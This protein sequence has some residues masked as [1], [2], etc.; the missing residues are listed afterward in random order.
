[1]LSEAFDRKEAIYNAITSNGTRVLAAS[2]KYNTGGLENFDDEPAL[3]QRLA[4]GDTMVQYWTDGSWHRGGD[5]IGLSA[6]AIAFQELYAGKQRWLGQSMGLGSFVG[7]SYDS[8]VQAI[9]MAL[10]HAVDRHRRGEVFQHV[11]V[12]SDSQ[13]VL[14]MLASGIHV[15]GRARPPYLG[16]LPENGGQWALEKIYGRADDLSQLG[17]RV[18][19]RWTR[20]HE[21][22]SSHGNK[23]ADD[24]AK[25]ANDKQIE[26]LGTRNIWALNGIVPQEYSTPNPVR[27]EYLF[28]RSQP[29]LDH[30]F[31]P[32]LLPPMPA[33]PPPPR[34]PTPPPPPLPTN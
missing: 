33:G 17:V 10:E 34:T 14:E 16:P 7:D 2:I 4:V 8:E 22:W 5:K 29:F 15:H 20:A 27:R 19:I 21:S 13:W 9:C 6:A 28:R 30:G 24:Q 11:M 1:M 32:C 3:K 31:G 26:K 23:I 25:R 18:Y 12:W